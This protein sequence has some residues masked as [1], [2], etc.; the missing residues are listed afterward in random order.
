[1]LDA[2]YISD[3]CYLYLPSGSELVVSCSSHQIQISACGRKVKH[4]VI[5]DVHY[6]SRGPS[7]FKVTRN[8]Q[9]SA[10]LTKIQKSRNEDGVRTW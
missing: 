10:R 5:L 2:F 8:Q 1:M 3:V 4:H 6:R 7:A 9:D